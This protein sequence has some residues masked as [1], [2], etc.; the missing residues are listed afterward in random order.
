MLDDSAPAAGV[1][2][3][4]FTIGISIF[5]AM[6]AGAGFLEARRVRQRDE[7]IDYRAFRSAWFNA[8]RSLI[9]F[10]RSVD[11]FETYMFEDGYSRR[12]FRIGSVRLT[13]DGHRKQQMRR[14]KGQ[15]LT[16][17]NTLSDNLDD[18]SE[19]LSE[20]DLP[21]IDAILTRLAEIGQLPERYTDLIRL[22]REAVDL[23]DD[24][25]T[26][27]GDREGFEEGGDHTSRPV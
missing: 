3:D 27:V 16:T 19:Y 8:R 13:I 6:A 4:P 23:Y 25:L 15:A 5:S 11:E 7:Q 24:L 26:G 20:A 21:A 14:L 12:A 2:P 17:A 18:L 10:K 1:D 22:G 9:F